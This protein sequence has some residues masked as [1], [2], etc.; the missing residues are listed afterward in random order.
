MIYCLQETHLE[1]ND[2]CNLK[3]KEWG[4]RHLR[5]VEALPS[6]CE[7]QA[8]FPA[9]HKKKRKEKEGGERRGEG[10]EE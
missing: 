6:M 2:L 9:P 7:T 8:Q 4:W 10:E 5:V 3:V 1:Y